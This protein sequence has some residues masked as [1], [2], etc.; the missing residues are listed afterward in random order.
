MSVL[1]VHELHEARD[2]LLLLRNKL[3]AARQHEVPAYRDYLDEQIVALNKALDDAR[4]PDSYRVAV[5]GRFKVGK[6]SF[7]NKLAQE[8]LASVDSSPE[9]AAISIF[10][11]GEE[12]TAE[13]EFVTAEE[14]QELATSYAENPKDAEAKRYAGFMGF[15]ERPIKKDKDGKEV[16][17]A[18]VDLPSLAG[19]WIQAGGLKHTIHASEWKTRPGKQAF[20]KELKQFT[21]SQEPL[22][23]LVKK[24]TIRAP[25]PLLRDHIELI[26]T[27]GLDDTE[28]FR[29]QLTEDLVRDVD[30]ILYLTTSGAAYGQGDKDFLIRQLRQQQLKHLQLIVTKADET[31]ENTVRDARENDDTPPTF[32]QF[33]AKEISRVRGEVRVTLDELLTSN[34][35]KD[36]DGYYYINQL[37]G[38]G[39]HLIST[40]L[41]DEG[42][43]ESGGIESVREGLYSVLSTSKRFADSRK[44]LVDRL[45]STLASLRTRF[46]DRIN[47]IEKDYDAKR[48]TA[49]IESIKAGLSTRLDFFEG[50]AAALIAQL[51]QKQDAFN[52]TLQFKL[53]AICL[54]AREVISANELDDVAT[55]WKSRRHRNWGYLADLQGRVADRIFPRVASN[56]KELRDQLSEFITFFSQR[57]DALQVE[58]GKLEEAH[59]IS[60]L[61]ALSLAEKQRPVFEKLEQEFSE[62]S[63]SA[64]DSVLQHLD[65]FVTEEVLTRLDAVKGNVSQVLGKGTTVRQTEEVKRFYNQVKTLLA[66]ALRKHLEKRTREFA[67][68]IIKH[69]QSLAPRLRSESLG[70]IEQRLKAIASNLELKSAEEK[71]RVL[72]YLQDLH[73]LVSN[74]AAR[75]ES[76]ANASAVEAKPDHNGA[77]VDVQSITVLQ[78]TRYEIADGAT[79]YT[80]ERIFRPYI[81]TAEEIIVE[82][83]YIRKAYQFDNFARFC[84]LA[85]RFGVVRKITLHTYSDFGEDIDEVRSRL[86]TLRRDLKSRNIELDFNYEYRG[87]D[88]EVR[89]NNGWRVNI[90]R[91]LDIYY[92]PEN[93][94]SVE[95]SEFSLRRCKGTKIE[96]ARC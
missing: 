66:D 10:R 61:G 83:P 41:H 16:V 31:Y 80:Y 33:R 39:V 24:V 19:K 88:R 12:T 9:T 70:L 57:I 86:E 50:E 51:D 46:G 56:L 93:W 75:P 18:P 92:P 7:I 22:H 84:A 17:H 8:I 74:F 73:A 1:L 76:T 49:E 5:V 21:S 69:A 55:H 36:E 4:I 38:I 68:A 28:R 82:D 60:G 52:K 35:T 23:Y 90:G 72:A 59:H 81:D 40:K 32:E 14:W 43:V 34:D 91:G 63:E 15:N 67:K 29:V 45:E 89:F 62:L 54:V 58:I 25:I 11:Y 37:D 48:V 27:P 13:I 87:H 64:R 65:D 53:D 2:R 3:T 30:A 78:P 71:Q 85:L 42:N 6:S 77:E 96:A 44:V 47:A 79:G 95:A 26:D 94:A 20:R